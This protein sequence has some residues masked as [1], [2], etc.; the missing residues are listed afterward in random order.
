[1]LNALK[2]LL[3]D[4]VVG[5]FS[6]MVAALLR[7]KGVRVGRRFRA[8]GWPN[9][10][11]AAGSTVT[12]GDDVTLRAGVDIFTRGTSTVAIGNNV[13]IDRGARLL[14]A[15]GAVLSVRDGSRVGPHCVINAGADVV[16]GEK[17]LIAGMCY[18][19]AS[20]HGLEGDGPII[21][22]PHSH[23][24]V[25]IGDGAWLAAGVTVLK[26]VRFGRGSVAAA[27]AVVTE[28]LPDAAIVGGIPAKVLK[29]R[30]P[31]GG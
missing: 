27:G 11:L 19:Q 28:D 2:L 3:G 24:P 30:P 20:D 7:A 21:D 29:P 15:R 10:E 12:I 8:E 26:G 13:R 6:G 14:S 4:W 5:L 1:M 18:I 23:A 25:T 16:I 31:V 9:L 17:V 22:L